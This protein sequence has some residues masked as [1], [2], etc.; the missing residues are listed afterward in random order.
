MSV[1]LTDIL[2]Q[3]G[4]IYQIQQAWT[5]GRWPHALLLTGPDGVG[6]RSLALAVGAMLLCSQ[7]VDVPASTLAATGHEALVPLGS[8]RQAC[9]HCPDCRMTAAMTHPDLHLVYK[10]L[11]RYHDDEKVRHQKMQELGIPVIRQ[12]LIDQAGRASS[13]GRGKVFIV[14]EADLMSV[15][16]QNSLLKTLEEPPRGVTLLL[17]AESAQQLLPTTVSRCTQV[18]L[19][20]LPVELVRRRLIEQGT[21]ADQATFWSVFTQGSIG[22]AIQLAGQGLYAT[23]RE[24]VDE[25]AVMDRIGDASWGPALDKRIEKLSEKIIRQAKKDSGVELAKTV[26]SRNAGTMLLSLLAGAFADALTLATG[27]DLP[28]ASADQRPQIE[29]IVRRLSTHELTDVLDQLATYEQLLW[30]NVNLKI[31]CDNIAITCA[32]PVPLGI[33]GV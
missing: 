12:F 18:R 31:L 6:R 20:P 19:G 33:E 10:E 25:L 7:S 13:R 14:L 26:A 1:A 3:D 22:R 24:L 27:A 28:I 30:R 21:P 8:L 9:G 2:A 15:E 4:A 11:A 32:A 5:S 23:K 17:I 16:A 29:A